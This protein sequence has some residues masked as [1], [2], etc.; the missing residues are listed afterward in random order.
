MSKP[1]IILWDWDNTLLDSRK[2]AEKALRQVGQETGVSIT[3]DDVTEVI[4]G[5][6][7]DFWYRHYGPN[8]IPIV[9]KFVAYYC[10]NASESKL[11]PETR[12]VLSW[13]QKQN[14][15]QIVVSNK[16]QEILIQEA[17]RFGIESYFQNLFG[18]INQ[19][20]GKPSR[21]FAERVF[22]TDWPKHILMIGDGESDMVFAET[23]G[24][25]G[26]FIGQKKEGQSFSY[27]QNVA[28]LTEV[29]QFLKEY[30]L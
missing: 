28:N 23:I 24:A 5:H 13:V 15:P 11:F 20:P 26:L 19:G 8:P 21:A 29:Y 30:I 1:D 2:V 14:I 3:V 27:H 4:G 18:T 25:F 7:V 16:N 22:G 12:D 17:Q 6:L 10:E 9:R